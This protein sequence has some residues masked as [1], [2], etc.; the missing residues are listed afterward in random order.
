MTRFNAAPLYAVLLAAACAA[1]AM[2]QEATAGKSGDQ[3]W[4]SLDADGNG[5]LSKSEAA[6][7][8]ALAQ[9]Y[10]QADTNADGQLSA[11]EYRAFIAARSSAA[12]PVHNADVND[13]TEPEE[14]S[15]VN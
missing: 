8:T 10:D 5:S 13:T 12:T 9:V 14:D 3:S 7:H 2:A 4:A 6:S 1:P 15:P 11:D